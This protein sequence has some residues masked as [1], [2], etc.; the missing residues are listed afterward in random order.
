MLKARP[1]W[2]RLHG[3]M[4][5]TTENV[6]IYMTEIYM[7]VV[8]HVAA[9][10]TKRGHG[11]FFFVEHLATG[12]VRC[13]ELPPPAGEHRRDPSLGDEA[14]ALVNWML[15]LYSQHCVESAPLMLPG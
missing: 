10:P 8:P 5:Q 9:F 7:T 15:Q 3:E 2:G 4:R 12:V 6:E 13:L 11:G 1:T 14:Q